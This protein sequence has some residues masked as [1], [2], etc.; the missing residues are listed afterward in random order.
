MRTQLSYRRDGQTDGRTD[1]RTD[2]FSA[3]YS[4]Y[5]TLFLFDP[6][7]QNTLYIYIYMYILYAILTTEDLGK[8]LI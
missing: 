1:R 6:P 4:R 3:L 8:C 7:T 5:S 2:G